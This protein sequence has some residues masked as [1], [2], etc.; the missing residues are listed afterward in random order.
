MMGLQGRTGAC[1]HIQ[2]HLDNELLNFVID[3]QE[4]RY[5]GWWER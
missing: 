4:A 3:D 5:D 1:P 2:T